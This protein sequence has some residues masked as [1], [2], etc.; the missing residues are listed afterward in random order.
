MLIEFWTTLKATEPK[1]CH[2]EFLIPI[3]RAVVF[4]NLE[5]TFI[6]QVRLNTRF[7]I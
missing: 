6:R 1:A 4:G 7:F 2:V 5:G 3:R